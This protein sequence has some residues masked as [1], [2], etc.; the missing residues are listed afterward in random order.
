MRWDP[1]RQL[2]R[3]STLS[4]V[5]SGVRQLY[6]P[7]TLLFIT[8]FGHDVRDLP[9]VIEAAQGVEVALS[10][11]QGRGEELVAIAAFGTG[12]NNRRGFGK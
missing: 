9:L 4:S 10:P 7:L 1:V 11:L 8:L 6:Y 3:P 12:E 5:S 2:C